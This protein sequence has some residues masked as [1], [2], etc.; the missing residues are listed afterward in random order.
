MSN[1]H[2][3]ILYHF[4]FLIYS[5]LAGAVKLYSFTI[6]FIPTNSESVSQILTNHLSAT[7]HKVST[8]HVHSY[9]LQT[10][11][12]YMSPV[13]AFHPSPTL[14][15]FH[16]PLSWL[17]VPPSPSYSNQK[18]EIIVDSFFFLTSNIQAAARFY[19]FLSQIQI[20]LCISTSTI[21][22]QSPHCYSVP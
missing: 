15:P 10:L 20:C 13:I 18:P 1:S 19:W 17:M 14:L 7:L 16:F 22:F 11:L 2:R 4:H 21:R 12:L 9:L 5:A 3:F 6:M 8:E